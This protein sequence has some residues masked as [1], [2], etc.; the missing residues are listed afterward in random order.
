M[1]VTNV[2][3]PLKKRSAFLKLIKFLPVRTAKAKIPERKFLQY[4]LLELLVWE[5]QAPPPADAVPQGLLPELDNSHA[6]VSRF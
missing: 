3:N 2:V 4:F 6:T 1:N 5:L